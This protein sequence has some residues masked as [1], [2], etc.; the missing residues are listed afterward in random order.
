MV[1]F[2]LSIVQCNDE[3]N[4]YINIFMNKIIR[5]YLNTESIIH[6]NI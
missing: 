5:R 1:N 4:Y 3:I 6:Q 2:F